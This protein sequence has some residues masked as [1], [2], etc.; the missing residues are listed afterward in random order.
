MK[1]FG[2]HAVAMAAI[3]AF[4]T[5]AFCADISLPAPQTS[6]GQGIFTLLKAR[7]S[8]VPADFPLKAISQQE[9]SNLLWAATGKNRPN[10][11]TIP[12]ARH[13]PPYNK[14]Y[15]LDD[16]GIYRYDWEQN[17]LA[18]I[19]G[20]NIKSTVGKQDIAGQSAVIL[21]FV[22]DNKTKKEYAYTATG[23]MTQNI[24]LSAA[25]MG[26]E[27]RFVMSMNEDILRQE[28]KLTP[29]EFPLNMMLIGK[30]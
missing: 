3:L 5:A 16:S 28:L 8:A 29:D 25:S 21:V 19:S 26:I 9:L 20:K 6:G 14:I 27:G 1:L 7:H 17:K 22:S 24:Y 4:S 23:A 18:E 12:L 30:K 11:W 2:K 10:G 15:V 13:R